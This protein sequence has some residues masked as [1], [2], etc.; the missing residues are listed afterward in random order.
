MITKFGAISPQIFLA[1]RLLNPP[2]WILP[3]DSWTTNTS[4]VHN[5]SS[6]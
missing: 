6:L 1:N 2:M 3:S 5:Q 4:N